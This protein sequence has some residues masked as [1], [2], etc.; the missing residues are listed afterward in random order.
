[1]NGYDGLDDEPEAQVFDVREYPIEPR[2]GDVSWRM[3]RTQVTQTVTDAAGHP[4]SGGYG[5]PRR[6]GLAHGATPWLQ[7]I[8]ANTVAIGRAI[9]LL[10]LDV[11]GAAVTVTLLVRVLEWLT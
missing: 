3:R 9:L 10:V 2:G 7:T 1:V 11:A 8:A 5:Y 4:Y 6:G